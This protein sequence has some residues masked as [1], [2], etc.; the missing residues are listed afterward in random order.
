MTN[1]QSK[2]RQTER[3]TVSRRNKR[4]NLRFPVWLA[5]PSADERTQ[6][7]QAHTV[8][9]SHA[10]ATLELDEVI[11]VGVGLQ[12]S[13]PFGGTILA[14]V[15][16]AWTERVSG[17]HRISIRLIDPVAWTSPERFSVSGCVV[18]E[19]V[20]LGVH[21]RLGQML[22]DYTDYLNATEGGGVTPSVAAENILER[23]FLSDG[24]FQDW[25]AAKIMDD[26]SAWEE[27]YVKPR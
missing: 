15:T 19:W 7:L 12:V 4:I 2:R 11:P 22:A 18:T 21:P 14:E 6:A 26:L 23:A 27:S 3:K 24:N 17:R 8:V 9:V 10:G 5:V 1:E 13:P 16:D 25:L 20:R